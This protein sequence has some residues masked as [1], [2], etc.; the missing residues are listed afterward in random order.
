M[1]RSLYPFEKKRPY[2]KTSYSKDKKSFAPRVGSLFVFGTFRVVAFELAI[3]KKGL[4]LLWLGL[5]LG[6]GLG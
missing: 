1:I 2:K 3:A 5:G 4:V 6:L